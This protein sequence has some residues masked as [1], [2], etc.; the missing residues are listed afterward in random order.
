MKMIL[1]SKAFGNTIATNKIRQNLNIDVK[2]AKILFVPT[3]LGGLYSYDKYLPE[4]I[5]FGFKEYNIVIF[6]EKEAAATGNYQP[7]G[8]QLID[9]LIQK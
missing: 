2:K 5:N 1:T 6:N 3:A 9:R 4:I 7:N 8:Y